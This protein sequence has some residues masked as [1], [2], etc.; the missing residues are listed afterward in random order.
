[1]PVMPGK[2]DVR[3]STKAVKLGYTVKFEIKTVGNYYDEL[4]MSR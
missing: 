3:L 1:M 2:N 4:I